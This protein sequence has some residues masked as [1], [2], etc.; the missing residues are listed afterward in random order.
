MASNEINEFIAPA[1]SKLATPNTKSNVLAEA[2]REAQL[3]IQQNIEARASKLTDSG[4]K[5]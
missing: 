5:K 2:R 3:R 4:K 1:K